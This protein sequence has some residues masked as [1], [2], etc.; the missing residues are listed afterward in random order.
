MPHIVAA[1][2]TA[3]YCMDDMMYPCS[4]IDGSDLVPVVWLHHVE[5]YPPQPTAAQRPNG[6][7][8]LTDTT[9]FNQIDALL[10]LLFSALIWSSSF[11]SIG[12][13]FD[14]Y[15]GRFRRVHRPFMPS[16]H[17]LHFEHKFPRIVSTYYTY[18][19]TPT[20][21]RTYIHHR[22]FTMSLHRPVTEESAIMG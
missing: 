7:L 15:K 18:F 3:M 5:S 16:R 12:S 10:L 6:P 20:Y 4:A 1:Y 21:I 19:L 14:T 22:L 13:R 8:I 9:A 11:T 2:N 17:S